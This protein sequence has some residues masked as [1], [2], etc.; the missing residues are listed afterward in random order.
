MNK[1]YDKLLAWHVT[2]T[3]IH[4]HLPALL[5]WSLNCDH[6]TEMG[7]RSVVSTWAFMAAKPKRLVSIDIERSNN[8]D[9]ALALAAENGIDMEFLLQDTIAEDFEIEETD[10][11]F[12]DT[13]HTYSQL[14][15]E[16]F[17]HG[18][19]ARKFIGFHDTETY[20]LKNEP[21]FETLDGPQGLRPAVEEFL[22]ANPHWH[23]VA[24]YP[25][26]NGLTILVRQ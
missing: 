6:I 9:E 2:P 10:F 4:L 14:K 23:M 22:I 15:Q 25:Y 16:L 8:I 1:I 18:N 12:I 5:T 17:R 13:L 20:G 26:C 3:D 21:G 24:H 19:R 7:V 11:L